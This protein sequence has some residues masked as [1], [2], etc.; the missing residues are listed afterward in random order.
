MI[1]PI[2]QEE[3]NALE[4]LTNSAKQADSELQRQLAARQALIKLLEGKYKATFDEK[5]GQFKKR[6]K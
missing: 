5:T 1:A 2:T 3:T 4:I 6:I